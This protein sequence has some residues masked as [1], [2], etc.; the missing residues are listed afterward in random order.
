MVDKNIINQFVL[1]QLMSSSNFDKLEGNCPIDYIEKNVISINNVEKLNCLNKVTQQVLKGRT[2][3]FIE[4]CRE[5]LLIESKGYEK[6]GIEKP[7]T[8]TVIRGPQEGFTEDL[9][10]NIT[11]LR[12]N[13]KNEKFVTEI[14]P[15]GNTSKNECAVM[16]LEGVASPEVVKEVK[17]RIAG[18]ELD[19]IQGDGMLEQ[20]IEDNPFSLFPQILST[21]RPDRASSFIMEGQVVIVTEGTPFALAV[22]VTLYKLL[23][24]SEDYHLRWQ[25]GTFLR[26]VR[27]LGLIISIFLPALYAGLTL[28]HQEMIPTELLVSI[29]KA[30]ENVPFPVVL[31]LLIMEVSFELI[32]EGG[33][34]VPG[35]IGQTLGI[36]GA[37]ILGQAAVAA[38]LVSPILIIIVAVTGLGSFSIPSYSLALGIRMM[39][40][41]FI[42]SASI[43]GFY[44]LSVAI[45]I[46]LGML[47]NIKSFGVPFLS[48][49]APKTKINPDVVVR[50]PLWRQNNRPDYINSPDR[51]RA[52]DPT[53]KWTKQKNGGKTNDKGR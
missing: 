4:G 26:L 8:E 31:E 43:A 20:L 1:P 40:F 21:E 13:I 12:R 5:C 37:L 33:I 49:I 48:P 52:G 17:R 24:T 2:A 3:L 44:S 32:R 16:Y 22:P 51:K 11:L 46:F 30:R 53:R 38:G 36:I 47:C 10:T 29:T 19:F 34:R 39:R 14:L 23:H 35:V 50:Q 28:Y 9:R 25:Y 41:I 15:V 42:V 7:A 18:L 27:V 6:R 45:I